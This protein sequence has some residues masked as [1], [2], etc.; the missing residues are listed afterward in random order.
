MECSGRAAAVGC[1]VK[2][3]F[4]GSTTLCRRRVEDYV[5][6]R[7]TTTAVLCFCVLAEE[8]RLSQQQLQQ[9]VCACVHAALSSMKRGRRRRAAA[10]TGERACMDTRER[11]ATKSLLKSH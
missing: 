7:G 9:F 10:A 6:S 3:V 4:S 1:A 11:G 8:E 5:L 2:A